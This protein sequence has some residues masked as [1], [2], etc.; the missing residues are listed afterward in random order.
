MTPLVPFAIGILGAVLSEQQSSGEGPRTLPQNVIDDVKRKWGE[1]ALSQLITEWPSATPLKQGDRVQT[2]RGFGWLLGFRLTESGLFPQIYHDDDGSWEGYR[3]NQIAPSAFGAVP[4]MTKTV[5]KVAPT[6]FTQGTTLSEI[7]KTKGLVEKKVLDGGKKKKKKKTPWPTGPSDEDDKGTDEEGDEEE[8]TED[9][10]T[11]EEIV[12]AEINKELLLDS[13][14]DDVLLD[15]DIGEY[16]E[17]LEESLPSDEEFL[18][19][20]EPLGTSGDEEF[21]F[22]S[23]YGAFW[24][25]KSKRDRLKRGRIRKKLKK[26]M[27]KGKMGSRRWNKLVDKF[28]MH[29]GDINKFLRRHGEGDEE[30]GISHQSD[31]IPPTRPRRR[32]TASQGMFDLNSGWGIRKVN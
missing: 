14:A 32:H 13:I 28:H 19:E 9:T 25:K 8:E 4:T 7:I 12:D 29:G 31:D 16:D 20:Y 11:P 10:R 27:D 21:G 26:L 24:H 30:Y 1:N 22:W 15:M 17:D 23:R 2:K 18:S 5:T 6:R 3:L